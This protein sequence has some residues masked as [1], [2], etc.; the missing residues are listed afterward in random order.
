MCTYLWEEPNIINSAACIPSA[1]LIK[2]SNYKCT[3]IVRAGNYFQ[4]HTT[5]LPSIE[6]IEKHVTNFNGV[7]Y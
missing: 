6:D 4:M 2:T 3:S 7:S 5:L 1:H